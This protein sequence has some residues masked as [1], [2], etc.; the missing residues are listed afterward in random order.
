MKLGVLAQR[1]GLALAEGQDAQVT[2]FAIDN[3]KVAQGCVFGAFQGAS[4]NG[5]QFIDRKSV[6]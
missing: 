2:G 4:V 5:E 3:R 1:A 6:V